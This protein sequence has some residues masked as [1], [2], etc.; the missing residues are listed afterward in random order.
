MHSSGHVGRIGASEEF[1]LV[2]VPELGFTHKDKPY[3]RGHLFLRGANVTCG[4]YKLPERNHEVRDEDG[5]RR[6]GDAVMLVEGNALKIL[7][8]LDALFNL[9]NR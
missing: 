8:R 6:T 7:D 4:Y 3:P 1:K 5:W 2:D 9:K